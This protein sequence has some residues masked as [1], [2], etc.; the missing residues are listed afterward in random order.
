MY[1]NLGLPLSSG[2]RTRETIVGT[3]AQIAALGSFD[4]T[5]QYS[6]S[7]YPEGGIS[8]ALMALALTAPYDGF[9]KDGDTFICNDT[10]ADYTKDKT[11]RFTVTGTLPNLSA[12]WVEVQSS[13][14]SVIT[15][16]E[17]V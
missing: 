17:Y 5:K 16:E 4:K 15:F 9:F 6:I 14:G 3:M 13:S 8:S 2:G 1:D 12:S 11:Y 7:D 10:S